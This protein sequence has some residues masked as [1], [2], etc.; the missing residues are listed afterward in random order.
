MKAQ[1]TQSKLQS[2][3]IQRINLTMLRFATAGFFYILLTPMVKASTPHYSVNTPFNQSAPTTVVTPMNTMFY[4]AKTPLGIP[5][6]T[7][8]TLQQRVFNGPH[9]AALAGK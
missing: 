6:S 8:T 7:V 1:R 9:V 2:L 4:N 5:Q 3:S